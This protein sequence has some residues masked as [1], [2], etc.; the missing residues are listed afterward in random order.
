M[1]FLK[2]LGLNN[3][4]SVVSNDEGITI[5]ISSK[6]EPDNLTA[7]DNEAIQQPPKISSPK[8][9][10]YKVIVMGDNSKI[11]ITVAAQKTT[12][13]AVIT[14]L[15][16]FEIDNCTVQ[17]QD[18]PSRQINNAYYRG[19][20]AIFITNNEFSD[21]EN[22]YRHIK[23]SCE[24]STKMVIVSAD[25]TNQDIIEFAKKNELILMNATSQNPIEL[26]ANIVNVCSGKPL[27]YVDRPEVQ[28]TKMISTEE[29]MDC[30][31]NCN[32]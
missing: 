17:M 18:A 6:S 30:N 3:L 28:G 25:V 2:K 5:K 22:L 19:A 21:I 10:T 23:Y 13:H 9:E 16:K 27:K 31:I 29:Y 7:I 24:E 4:T 15:A 1:F 12:N 20:H 14:D 32:R 8:K 11:F 26:R